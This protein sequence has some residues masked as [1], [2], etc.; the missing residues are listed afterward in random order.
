MASA[1]LAVGSGLTLPSFPPLFPSAQ[2]LVTHSPAF[3]S[4]EV[5]PFP[6]SHLHLPLC[7][8]THLGAGAPA[9][10][11]ESLGAVSCSFP[12]LGLKAQEGPR[13]SEPTRVFVPVVFRGLFLSSAT[14]CPASAISTD[15]AE[16]TP[17]LTKCQRHRHVLTQGITGRAAMSAMWSAPGRLGVPKLA[18]TE[19]AL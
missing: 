8:R 2:S 1:P 7:V 17:P 14:G 9:D 13:T 3:G 15:C 12:L 18:H 19:L 5:W 11:G 6:A 16:L 4:P 10:P